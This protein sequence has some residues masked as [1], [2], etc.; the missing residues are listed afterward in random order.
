MIKKILMLTAMMVLLV[1]KATAAAE[2]YAELEYNGNTLTFYY[3]DKKSERSGKTC[4]EQAEWRKFDY[5]VTKVVFD[6]SFS[7]YRPTSLSTWFYDFNE[8]RSIEGIEN[9]NTSEVENMA[10]MFYNCRLLGSID[11]SHFDTHKVTNMSNM[12]QKCVRLFSLD[13]SHFDTRNVTSM[14]GM[15]HYCKNLTSLDLGNFDTRNVTEM[16]NMFNSCE[17]LTSLNVS[18]F[19]TRNVINMFQ[20]FTYCKK[21]T[22]LGLGNFDT[23]NVTD[24]LGMFCGC[25]S[26]TSLDLSHFDISSV[27]TMENMFAYCDKLTRLDLKNFD[28]KKVA[29]F[30]HMFFGCSSLRTIY[31]NYD[32]Y[33]IINVEDIDRMFVNCYA[34]TGLCGTTCDE[35]GSTYNKDLH[36]ARPDI[37][38]HPGYFTPRDCIFVDSELVTGTVPNK[39]VSKIQEGA[40]YVTYN[41][42]EGVL[43]MTNASLT[44]TGEGFFITD[45]VTIRLSGPNR[46]T[47]T[48]NGITMLSECYIEGSGSL[49]V[50]SFDG[51]GL[52]FSEGL[53][54]NGTGWLD[55]YGKLGAL[56][57]RPWT[58]NFGKVCYGYL[59]PSQEMRL[60]TDGQHP[61]VHDL[62]T[63]ERGD[64]VMN[65]DTYSYA[66]YYRTVV[67]K[68]S[69]KSVTKPF[70]IVPKDKMEYF[71]ITL[72]G[73][74]LNNHNADNFDP[75]SLTSGT[76]TYNDAT[77][78]LTL[79]N[80]NFGDY[81]VNED[82]GLEVNLQDFTLELKGNNSIVGKDEESF[83]GISF[84]EKDLDNKYMRNWR[85]K[86]VTGTGEQRG[87]LRYK[88]PMY[89]ES[90]ECTAYVTFTNMNLVCEDDCYLWSQDNVDM[91]IDD[92][93]FDL[94][95]KTPSD[96]GIMESLH[97]LTLKDCH[98]EN[99]CYWDD[100][101]NGVLNRSGKP[102][103][104]HISI[105]RGE[106]TSIYGDVNGDGSVDVADIASVISVMAGSA[107]YEA[108]DVNG[109]GS[110]DVAD[111][112]TI[113]SIMA[114]K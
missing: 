97:S 109:D 18:S 11:L 99:G 56:D 92:C 93:N 47:S 52:S 36:K 2:M 30:S 58:N 111:I 12:F 60:R 89:F 110:I 31:C 73:N 91:T 70:T 54:T 65:Y 8:L 59:D 43:Y 76:V 46:I 32:W 66:S 6:D 113:I 72:G 96:F 41:A 57:G 82:Y 20:M 9:L 69:K 64:W 80:A 17:N 16:Q 27:T 15:F 75:M 63:I 1:T 71:P 100:E 44:T 98:F 29:N 108:A 105:K 38:G 37:P 7:N 107:D 106:A 77:H 90:M 25:K 24:M 53:L 103:S 104:R 5:L 23:S 112:A 51:Y 114:G 28:T 85:I 78:T 62:G 84:G 81:E 83:Y 26:L 10:S 101:W 4:T 33:K 13:L 102:E 14:Y 35:T 48:G 3:D 22:S 49:S 45:A 88:G 21:L 67:D 40:S 34:L 19:D 74:Q 39:Y 95:D 55:I 94:W 86:G 87:T 42:E 68:Y 50:F 79:D 61:V